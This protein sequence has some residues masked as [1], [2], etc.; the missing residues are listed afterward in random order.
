MLNR[1]LIS[2]NGLLDEVLHNFSKSHA[3]LLI[4]APG[5]GASQ[6]AI[7]LAK[8]KLCEALPELRQSGACGACP[9]CHWFD[10][11]HHPDYRFLGL[12]TLTE[13]G[14]QGSNGDEAPAKA[15]PSGK[16][17][18]KP[19]Q[20]TVEA[21][22]AIENFAAVSGHRGGMRVVVIYPAEAL[23]AVAANRLLKTLEEPT[24]GLLF[25]LVAESVQRLLPTIR[26]RCQL[27]KIP[28]VEPADALAWLENQLLNLTPPLP[29][30]K[31]K[32]QAKA[33]LALAGGAPETALVLADPE[34]S[35][36]HR[37]LLAV[38]ARL[39]DTSVVDSAGAISGAEPLSFI[40]TLQR[41]I[42]DLCRVAAGAQPR[43]FVEQSE[44]LSKLAGRSDL[45]RLTQ[46]NHAVIRQRSLA[47]HPLNP[48]LYCEQALN[49]YCAAFPKPQTSNR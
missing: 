12:D 4:A 20:I 48:R 43:Y 44:R 18:R 23:N 22:K 33:L 34:V 7:A 31:I 24:D 40:S 46:A 16:K 19:T 9:S 26:S 49:D 3:L 32:D 17:K 1:E 21:V 47:S 2:R 39:P 30:E 15:E 36:I 11:N 25:I 35:A 10:L 5:H 28:P 6:F 38:I 13:D 27:I 45:R 8:A 37:D 29:P 42:E 41:W 14:D